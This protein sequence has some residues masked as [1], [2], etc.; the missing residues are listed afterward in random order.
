MKR[1]SKNLLTLMLA[2]ALCAATIG[3]A[4]ALAP[5]HADTTAES[6]YRLTQVFS[7]TGAT[8][9]SDKMNATDEKDTAKFTIQNAGYVEFNN[10]LAWKWYES[11]NSAKYLNFGFAFGDFNFTDVSFVF[12]TTP[13]QATKDDKAVNTIKF[14]NTDGV[15]SVKVYA[16]EDEPETGVTVT[17]TEKTAMKVQLTET[18]VGEYKVELDGVEIGAFT[19]VGSSY[20]DAEKV[21]TFVVKA[22][23]KTDATTKETSIYFTE[24]NGQSFANIVENKVEDT[25]EAVLVVNQDVNS[26]M[27]GA[28]FSL[29]Y[30]KIDVL[31][32]SGSELSETKKYYQWN[33]T[34][35]E[36]SETEFTTNPFFMDTVY[37]KEGVNTSVY[38]EEGYELVSIIFVLDDKSGE[39]KGEYDLSWYA[40]DVVEKTVTPAEGDPDTRDY[41]KLDRNEA[42]PTYNYIEA[43]ASS[44]P[45][46][47][48]ENVVS[49]A[50]ETAI[51]VYQAKVEEVAKEVY[52][53]SNAKFEVPAIDWLITDNNGFKNLKFTVS[54]KEPGATSAKTLTDKS[55]SALKISTEKEGIY[56]YK[57]FAKDALGNAM[58]YYLDGE[59]VEVTTNN[60]WDI[61]EIPSFS[62]E[63]LNRGIKTGDGEDD[64]TL[65]TEILNEEYS[66]TAIMIEGASEEGET[67]ALYKFSDKINDLYLTNVENLLAEV[68]FADLNTEADRLAREDTE[69]AVADRDY[70]EL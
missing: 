24:L 52:A 56:E 5:V 19:N 42:G 61:E 64:D 62:F 26:F 63:V 7:Y 18:T 53:G 33:P 16:G 46:E 13:Y 30:E 23:P 17:V 47:G 10:D 12:E 36:V 58:K 48:G 11:K 31:K 9:M 38:R 60:V 68:K 44:E 41:I 43:V 27:L 57:V 50:L 69:T 2:G 32:G 1:K 70:M 55:Q 8:I 54:Y 37:E 45:N 3:G 21:D 67:Y 35:T 66:M 49:D 4:T 20:A 14:V 29:D 40:T 28:Q 22:T 51:E 34:D 6:T 39:A 25:A 59:L 15:I 65:D